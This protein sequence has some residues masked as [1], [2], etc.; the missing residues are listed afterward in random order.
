MELKSYTYKVL[1]LF[2]NN[3]QFLVPKYQRDYSWEKDKI[4]DLLEDIDVARRKKHEHFMGFI[5]VSKKQETEDNIFEIIDGQ[6]RIATFAMLLSVIRDKFADNG[7]YRNARSI[8]EILQTSDPVESTSRLSCIVMNENNDPVFQKLIIEYPEELENSENIEE[9]WD[10]F[11]KRRMKEIKSISSS[12]SDKIMIKAY[13]QIKN[14]IE[15]KLENTQTLRSNTLIEKKEANKKIL[16][17]FLSLIYYKL[18]LIFTITDSFEHAY[19]IFETLNDRGIKLSLVDLLKNYIFYVAE[20]EGTI[21]SVNQIWRQITNTIDIEHLNDLLYYY[22]LSAHKKVTK[23]ILFREI[24]SHLRN[25]SRNRAMS[26]VSTLLKESKNYSI[27]LDPE[28]SESVSTKKLLKEYSRLKI[29]QS[30]PLLLSCMDKQPSRID[31]LLEVLINFTFRFYTI[32][33][34]NPRTLE[35]FWSE[36]AIKL[37]NGDIDFDGFKGELAHYYPDDQEFV[38]NFE[39]R[40]ITDNSIAKY[41]LAKI[42]NHLL[43]VRSGS[44]QRQREIIINPDTTEIT[45][46]HILP[47]TITGTKWDSIFN[48]E[49]HEIYVNRIGNF[50]LLTEDDNKAASNSDFNSKKINFKDSVIPTT[51]RLESYTEWNKDSIH[52]NQKHL[53]SIAKDIWT[54]DF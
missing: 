23:N 40:K 43:S 41:L 9:T 33:G 52:D 36:S 32:G 38:R 22:W 21:E 39:S 3:L 53:A 54:I 29:K 24:R 48:Q 28:N 34:N 27:I 30:N 8:Q 37:R 45:L 6:Q 44:T 47:K 25:Q 15:N 50:T 5:I 17:D 42:N 46:E 2:K 51:T 11:K 19:L 7:F 10:N 13:T 12:K 4:E 49:E 31:D 35:A 18:K 1:E 14:S 20:D 16:Q 26:F